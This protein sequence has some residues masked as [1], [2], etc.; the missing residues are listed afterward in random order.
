[1]DWRVAQAV[2][3]MLCKCK[4]LGSNFTKKILKGRKERGKEG[5]ERKRKKKDERKKG[6]KK[7][8]EKGG[9][10]GRK[11][12]RKERKEAREGSMSPRTQLILPSPSACYPFS[13]S[14]EFSW[15]QGAYQSVQHQ[16]YF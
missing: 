5:R 6:G 4:D 9:R 16:T 3:H 15:S 11:E 13:P 1:M 7:E 14:C 10:E 12:G 2:E 8:K